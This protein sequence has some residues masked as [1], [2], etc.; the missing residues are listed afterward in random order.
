M[1]TRPVYIVGSARLPFYKSMTKY[2]DIS[3]Q[4]LMTAAL[5][6]L[7][8]KMNLQDK[9]VGD[10]AFGALMNSSSNWNLARE[11]VL[12]T[13]LNPHSPAYT[14]QRACGTSLE[15]TLQ[16]ALK[17]SNY[18]I[19]NGL[20]GGVDTNSDL[21][22]MLRR[23]LAK[24]LLALNAAKDFKS[25]LKIIASFRLSDFKPEY[26]GIV[27]PRTQL[28]MGQHCEKMVKDWG[29]TRE[30]QDELAFISHKNTIE[31]Y[32]EGFYAD[33]VYEWMGSKRDGTP[34]ADT[35]IEKLAKLAPAFDRNGTGTLTAG[36]SSPLTDGAAA[37]YL[38]C[39]ET[40]REFNHPL[41][42]RFVDAEVA[43]VDFVH[44]EGLLMAPTIAVSELLKRNHLSLQ[45]F[46][47][48]EIHEAFAGQVLC[49]LKAWESAE[50][51]QRVLHR[52]A[53]LGSIDR[54]K[55]NIKGGSLALG[56]PF[57]ATGAR[58]VGALAKMLFQNKK[59]RGLISICT[60]GGMGIAAILEAV[61]ED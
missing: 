50:Y 13:S 54:S 26:P 52:D 2:K 46:D 27:E 53:P 5:E 31:A 17:I 32:N 34:R 42:A 49:T 51:C 58:I 37:V 28:S 4:E 7:V 60:A 25:K 48:Y 14:L 11:S 57:A 56:H 8:R 33:L 15:A 36:N 40:A 16:I 20:A 55:M 19:N 9:I 39:E 59:G 30:A 3:T 1:K 6:I 43:A 24:K 45:D 12:G 41:L 29:I 18:Q 22:I 10:S 35:S 44:E 61:G 21:P 38:S 23:S 47:I